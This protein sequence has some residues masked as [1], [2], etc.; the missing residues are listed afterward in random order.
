MAFNLQAFFDWSENIETRRQSL[1]HFAD[2]AGAQIQK[3]CAAWGDGLYLILHFDLLTVGV[4]GQRLDRD[5]VYEAVERC[6]HS[7]HGTRLGGSVYI[8]PLLPHRSSE[9]CAAKFWNTLRD[10]LAGQLVPGDS[11][12]VHY[13][14]D[15]RNLIGGIAQVV[16]DG[17]T[18]LTAANE[19]DS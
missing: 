14:P 5:E 1:L 4:D 13:A 3:G 19:P 8:V 2:S 6:V 16:P 12:Y 17:A 11:F 15:C 10:M 9:Q 18:A 7:N